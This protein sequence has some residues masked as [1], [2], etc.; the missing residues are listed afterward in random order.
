MKTKGQF[1]F[2]PPLEEEI[3][4]R[5]IRFVNERLLKSLFLC[6]VRIPLPTAKDETSV[7]ADILSK[8]RELL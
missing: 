8:P 6:T 7:S 5:L 3:R 4:I 2:M 1:H